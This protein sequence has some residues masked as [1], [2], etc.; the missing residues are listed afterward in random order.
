MPKLSRA[1]DDAREVSEAWE[2][3]A[4][5]TLADV[6]VRTPHGARRAHVIVRA[7]SWVVTARDGD[8][9]VRLTLGPT[10]M[11]VGGVTGRTACLDLLSVIVEAG[12]RDAAGVSSGLGVVIDAWVRSRERA[13]NERPRT[14]AA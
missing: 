2:A 13:A 8:D 5:R 10:G 3:Y 11:S 4:G 14:T 6:K 12:Y 1:N 7:G 9:D